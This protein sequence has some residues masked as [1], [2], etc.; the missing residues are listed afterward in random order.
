MVA[1]NTCQ[2]LPREEK[3]SSKSS[4]E[5]YDDFSP[6]SSKNL[7]GSLAEITIDQIQDQN[8]PSLQ[9]TEPDDTADC[10]PNRNLSDDM[11]ISNFQPKTMKPST[12]DEHN[13]YFGTSPRRLF[14]T[15]RAIDD[16]LK[17]IITK[18][19][20]GKIKFWIQSKW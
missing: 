6:K 11:N 14:N 18:I 2:N 12:R 20:K 7:K 10:I 19:E 1:D 9:D 13:T 16:F 5:N 8:Q 15:D 4:A 17:P 3:N